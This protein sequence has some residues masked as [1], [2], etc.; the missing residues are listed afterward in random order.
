M[1]RWRNFTHIINFHYLLFGLFRRTMFLHQSIVFN[2]SKLSFQLSIAKFYMNSAKF[3]RVSHYEN[4]CTPRQDISSID[5]RSKLIDSRSIHDS[6]SIVMELR[7]MEQVQRN[8]G[9]REGKANDRSLND[10]FVRLISTQSIEH[11]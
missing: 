11:V 3:Y 4:I 8:K 5:P 9:V 6:G 10:T 7:R 2:L 1:L